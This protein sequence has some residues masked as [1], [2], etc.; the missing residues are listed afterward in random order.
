V[1]SRLLGTNWV[2]NGAGRS[3]KAQPV[4]PYRTFRYPVA[5]TVFSNNIAILILLL[6]STV[7]SRLLGTNWVSNVSGRSAKAQPVVPYRTFRYTVACTVFSHHIS[8]PTLRPSD[9][10]YSRLLGTNWVSNGAGRSA[11]AQPVVPYRTFRYPVA[12]F[13]TA[14][15]TT[16]LK[17][18]LP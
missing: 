2:S 16:T 7:Y 4:V 17:T 1:Y 13:C 8:I 3:A 12:C 5:C 10:V 6:P 9:I 11:K 15:N 18:L 14:Y